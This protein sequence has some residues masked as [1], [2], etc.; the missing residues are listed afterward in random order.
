M[1]R[2]HFP[3]DA[4]RLVGTAGDR[5]FGV[6]GGD[7]IRSRVREELEAGRA[8]F[9]RLLTA[10]ARDGWNRRSHNRGWTNG[11]L[12][13]HIALGFF[14]VVP[15]VVVMRMFA[16]LPRSVSRTFARGLDA[17][18]PLFNWINGI[19]PRFGAKIFTS[20]RLGATFDSVHRLIL[21][22]VES[23]KSTDWSRGMHYPTK[24]EPRFSDFMTFQ[25]LFLYPTV[26]LRHHREQ[27]VLS[28]PALR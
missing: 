9:H 23:M 4:Y 5:N 2:D 6:A 3:C 12:M 25:D 8:E 13:F 24:W 27:L 28:P 11:Q 21:R 7:D 19:G 15:L 14:L 22:R 16:V 10:V 20:S 26:H 18:T 1:I 17:V